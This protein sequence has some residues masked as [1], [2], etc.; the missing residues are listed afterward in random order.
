MNATNRP[1]PGRATIYARLSHLRLG[2]EADDEDNSVE[3]QVKACQRYCAERGWQVVQVP[4][5][6][7]VSGYK[8][9]GL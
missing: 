3:R 1:Q 5:E 2:E 8:R 9:G 4:R 6:E 7:N